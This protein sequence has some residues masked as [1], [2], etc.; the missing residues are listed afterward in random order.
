[1]IRRPPRSTRTDTLFPYT[2][3]SDLASQISV[4]MT[5]RLVQTHTGRELISATVGEAFLY[6][7]ARTVLPGQTPVERDLSPLV[8]EVA[9]NLSVGSL[10]N[11]SASGA[12]TLGI[13]AI[14]LRGLGSQR[15][16][17]L[18]NGRRISPY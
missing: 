8:V 6:S 7:P 11:A 16:L 13:S 14:S 12:T 4:A 9:A 1:M 15:T 5:S 3:S 18:V 17:V 10:T 2:R